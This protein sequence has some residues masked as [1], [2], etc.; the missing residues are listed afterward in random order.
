MQVKNNCHNI[1][2]K[3]PLIYLNFLKTWIIKEV[4]KEKHKVNNKLIYLINMHILN[5]IKKLQ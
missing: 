3:I 4:Q 1:K 2:I 5:H